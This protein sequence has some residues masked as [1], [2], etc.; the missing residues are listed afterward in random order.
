MRTGTFLRE[1]LLSVCPSL[2]VSVC[3]YVSGFVCMCLCVCVCGADDGAQAC[4]C[5]SCMHPSP[6]VP[7]L[8]EVPGLELTPIR[9]C[10]FWILALKP[11]GSSD[12]GKLYSVS[13]KQKLKPLVRFPGRLCR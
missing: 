13:L 1:P 2:C 9:S 8:G 4:V 3:V 10:H 6:V 12:F 11:F 5:L 7:F